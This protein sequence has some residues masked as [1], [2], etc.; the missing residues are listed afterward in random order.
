MCVCV[1]VWTCSQLAVPAHVSRMVSHNAPQSSEWHAR[2]AAAEA[3][4]AQCEA[5][6][7]RSDA[8]AQAAMQAASAAEA[9][10]ATARD[11]AMHDARTAE[12]RQLTWE[13]R[14]IALNDRRRRRRR[15]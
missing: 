11:E 8:Q 10:L 15:R 12:T 1:C 9:R 2:R 7:R 5:A 4:A 6:V 3:R 13:A 14:E